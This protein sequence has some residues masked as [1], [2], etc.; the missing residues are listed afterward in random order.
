MADTPETKKTCFIAMPITTPA[1]LVK[2]YGDDPEHFRGVLDHIHVPAVEAAGFTPLRPLSRGSAV[3]QKDIIDNLKSADLVLMDMSALNANAFFEWGIRTALNRPVCVVRD[4]LTSHIPF[5]VNTINAHSYDW[6]MDPRVTTVEIPKLKQHLLDA[7]A[8]SRG[9]N[10]LWHLFGIDRVA[11]APSAPKNENEK[12]D[13]IISQMT[14]IGHRLSDLEQSRRPI[15]QQTRPSRQLVRVDGAARKAKN[16][17]TTMGYD[18]VSVETSGDEIWVFIADKLD[19]ERA[20]KLQA[21]LQVEV[22][23]HIKLHTADEF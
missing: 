12:L 19:S 5:D 8:E 17:L 3:I 16:E 13:L 10:N 15:T 22:S 2:E 6:R 14:G 7:F 4:T 23:P 1:H 18:V 11:V 21:F 20:A 9:T